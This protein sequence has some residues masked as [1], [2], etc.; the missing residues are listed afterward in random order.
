MAGYPRPELVASTE[1]LAANLG[2]QDVRVIDVRWRPD[3][4]GRATYATGHIPGAAYLDWLE[5]LVDRDP[6][7]GVLQLAGADRVAAALGEA[8]VTNTT[9]VVLY[10]DVGGLYAAR[11]WWSLRAYGLESARILDGGLRA[12][13]EGG[14]ALTSED[15]PPPAAIFHPSLQAGLRLTTADVQG[16]IRS[17]GVL[18]VDARA[19]AEY[20]GFEGNTRRLG[21]IPG[22]VNLPVASLTEP[23]TGRFQSSERLHDLLL[24]ANVVRGRRIVCYDGS[25]VAAAKLAF[26]LTLAGYDDVAV[27]DGGWAEWGDRLDLPVDR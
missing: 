8:G 18:L 17:T 21:H 13:T 26:L 12:W 16:L 19:T 14:G 23:G 25:G 6:E 3:G 5:Q 20:H 7:S 9:T 22:A 27:Y 15:R 11:A 10:D 4:S 24:K 1:W 2:G